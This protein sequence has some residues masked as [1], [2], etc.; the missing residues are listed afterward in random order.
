VSVEQVIAELEIL[1]ELKRRKSERK[2][3]SYFP[4]TGPFRRELYVKHLRILQGWDE[5]PRTAYACRQSYR[6]D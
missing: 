2:F 4:D 6:K 3:L 1:E 5:P